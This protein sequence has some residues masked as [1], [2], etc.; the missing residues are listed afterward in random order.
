MS[1]VVCVQQT[2]RRS[3]EERDNDVRAR[4]QDVGGYMIEVYDA[5]CHRGNQVKMYV[6]RSVKTIVE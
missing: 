6:I 2:T 1:C 5:Y 3:L 4:C